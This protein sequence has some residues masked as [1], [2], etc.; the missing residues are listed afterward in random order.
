[1]PKIKRS[2][3]KW[4]FLILALLLC[5]GVAYGIYRMRAAKPFEVTLDTVQARTITSIV[6]ATGKLQPQVEVVISSEVSGEVIEVPVREGMSVAAGD[7]LARIRADTYAAQVRQR[8]AAVAAAQARSLQN[9]AQKLQALA[10]QQRIEALAADGFATAADLEQARTA[11]QVREATHQSGLHEVKQQEMLLD[12][13]R[14][15]LAKT[16]LRAP[17]AGTVNRLAVESGER[18]VG[19]GLNPGTQMMAV[20]D[21]SRMEVRVEVSETDIVTVKPEDYVRIS[22]DALPRQRFRGR[23]TEI[24]SSAVVRDQGSQEQITTFQVRIALETLHPQ[25]RPGMTATVE[26]ETATVTDAITVPL[27]SVTVRDRRQLAGTTPAPEEGAPSEEQPSENGSENGTRRGTGGRDRETF[28][29]VVFV[30]DGSSARLR[31]V[32]TGI[33]D[34]NHIEIK[35]GL[36]VGERI[37]TGPY[38]IL[39]RELKEG[40]L[41]RER[42][43]REGGPGGGNRPGGRP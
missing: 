28:Q 26:I 15:E 29:R 2:R 23:V 13:A 33:A 17:M 18:V 42:A 19:T 35:S 4:I 6:S 34:T 30:L 39:T 40:S 41:V 31:R 16:V 5:G 36:R 24:A 1:M 7:L 3:K 37:I 9:L 10:D 25:M 11:A 22:I 14:D 27:Q 43:K 21:L 20:S 12:E 38:S 32:E 8:E